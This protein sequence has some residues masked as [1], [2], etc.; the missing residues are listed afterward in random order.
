[1]KRS[2]SSS[3]YCKFPTIHR[4]FMSRS[5]QRFFGSTPTL[6]PSAVIRAFRNFVDNN[7]APGHSARK[8]QPLSLR[9]RFL[10]GCC[11]KRPTHTTS[12]EGTRVASGAVLKHLPPAQWRGSAQVAY[13]PCMKNKLLKETTVISLLLHWP[14]SWVRA[15]LPH[16]LTQDH[17]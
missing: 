10:Y 2:R 16:H 11:A 15:R 9:I 3:I 5:P 4:G 17:R 13:L 12:N 7:F 8:I 6:I 1:M 14:P